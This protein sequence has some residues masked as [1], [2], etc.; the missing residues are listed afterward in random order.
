MATY[1][2]GLI[3]R[4]TLTLITSGH[5]LRADAAAAFKRLDDA[6]YAKFG[7]RISVTDGYRDLAQQVAVKA[8]KGVFAATPGKSNH[9]WGLALDLGSR[10]NLATSAEHE[11]MDAN[12]H[13]YGWVNPA[14]ARDSIASNGQFEPWHWEYVPALDQHDGIGD[15][16]TARPA[17]PTQKGFLMALSDAQQEQLRLDVTNIAAWLFGGGAGVDAGTAARGTVAQ[18]VINLDRQ[19]TGAQ[20]NDVNIVDAVGVLLARTNDVLRDAPVPLRQ[21]IADTKTMV[22]A[23]VSRS[24]PDV[25][26][27][28][29]AAA[30]APLLSAAT[31]TLSDEDLKRVATSVADEQARRLTNGA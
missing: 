12:A 20:D 26:E 13:R 18:R 16:V 28:A 30:L 15:A 17:T 3:P 8:I 23:L 1:A 11:W 5:R 14:W 19:L 4:S 21:E 24:G 31:P 29:L 2:N 22:T 9:G 7:K 25:D 27:A 10:I 6:F